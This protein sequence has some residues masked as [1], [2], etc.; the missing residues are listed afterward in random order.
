MSTYT[1][2]RARRSVPRLL[3]IVAATALGLGIA[4][5]ATA[6]PAAA[7]HQKVK[8][9]IKRDTLEVK[10][11]FRSD[12]IVLR[13][14]AGDSGTL[15][16]DSDGDGSADARFDRTRF[17]TIEVE[18]GF[19]DDSV[20]ID[21]VNG[22]FTDTEATTLDGGFGDDSLAGGSGPE[23]FRGGF[24]DDR[25]DGN[26]GD[27]TA[28]MGFGD[29]TFVW[30]PGDGSDHVEGQFGNEDAMLFNGA[31]AAE[32]FDVSANGERIRFFR[33]VGNIT[34]DLD[35]VERI[36]LNALGGADTVL[37][38]DVR[39]TDL[40]LVEANLAAALVGNAGDGQPDA[41][42]VKG[43]AAND[44]VQVDQDGAAMRVSGLAA[45]VRVTNGEPANDQVL[46]DPLDGTDR[47]TVNG[48]AAAET[49][50][51]AAAAVAGHIRVA[52]S[53]A[54]TS[55]DLVSTEALLVQTLGGDDTVAG[56]NGLATLTELTADGGSGNDTLGG[57]DGDDQLLG[58]SENDLV[59]GN[60]GDDTA[61]LGDGDDTFRWDP[62]DGSDVVEGQA[63]LDTLLF[64]GAGAAENID[65][66]A[67]GPRLRFFRDVANIT[68]DVDDTEKVFFQALG[69]AD[70]V[71]VNDLTGTDVVEVET[72]LAAAIGGAAGDGQA[73]TVTVNGTNGDDVIL[74]Q[75][76]NGLATV[77]GLTAFVRIENAE[78]AN[79]RLLLK[80]RAGDD[81]AI[82]AGLVA[83]A[84]GYT[85][86]GGDGDDVLIGSDGDDVLSGESGDD[87]M[88]G[89]PGAD[90]ISCGPGDD[91]AVSDGADTVAADC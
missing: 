9:K 37:V 84:I 67:N 68:M 7:H 15:E 62:G 28:F 81:V 72:D 23:V 52:S 2:A 71:V 10:G 82:A 79:D 44:L 65:I 59:D 21:E 77:T 38:N 56:S 70:N 74:S 80:A 13:L 73:D 6:A 40:D 53:T 50:T 75:G 46:V 26:R 51:I 1:P 48:S 27:D 39:G 76:Q 42:T 54:S 36:D 20:R 64:N 29:D 3:V 85:A 89:G 90:Q 78:P 55:I 19:G 16:L 31:G 32:A 17:D 30:D 43:T 69:G 66:S 49:I 4:S 11:T 60:R 12:T 35:G 34:M 47:V 5:Q 63:D 87:I 45:E 61:F 58:G 18:T 83:S 57:G 86:D 33:N 41:V 25:A 8:A 14:K 24:G 22:V 91:I 88:I